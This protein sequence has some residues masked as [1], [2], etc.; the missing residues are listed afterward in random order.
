MER[1][2]ALIRIDKVLEEKKYQNLTG[3]ALKMIALITMLI[4]HTAAFLICKFEFANSPLVSMGSHTITIYR[5][6]RLI[7]RLSFPIYCFLIT[8]G[9]IHTHDKKKYGINLLAFAVV[10]EIPWN[11]EYSGKIF[12]SS[13]NVFFT[14][15][16]GYLSI[17]LYEKYKEHSSELVLSM[18]AVFFVALCIKSDYGCKGVGFIL[19]LHILRDKKILQAFL[20]S[21]F[22]SAQYM[23]LVSFG[24][25]N[26]YNGE[27]GFIKGK[28]AKYA[29]YVIYP[30]HMLILYFIKER[31]YGY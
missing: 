6:L 22:L 29:F 14:L 18:L 26:M 19:L 8:E 13:Q 23:V 17:C 15:F 31:I 1:N 20:G 5:I 30:L 10:S 12:Y 16:L 3:S 4:D 25:I 24:L 7:G 21:C 27:R 2:N 11:L 9:Y 28:A